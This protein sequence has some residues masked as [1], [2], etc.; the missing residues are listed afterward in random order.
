MRSTILKLSLIV[1]KDWIPNFT[2]GMLLRWKSKI[3][4]CIWIEMC[5]DEYDII[6]CLRKTH[7]YYLPSQ[8]ECRDWMRKVFIAFPVPYYVRVGTCIT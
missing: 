2:Y 4:S 6:L 7:F 5:L 1:L 8:I 3:T